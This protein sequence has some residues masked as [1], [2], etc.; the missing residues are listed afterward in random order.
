M[1]G[2]SGWTSELGIQEYVVDN[3]LDRLDR[4]GLDEESSRSVVEFVRRLLMR[5]ERSA[6]GLRR[7]LRDMSARARSLVLVPATPR[8]W[9]RGRPPRTRAWSAS[10]LLPSRANSWMPPGVR[11]E[12][13]GPMAESGAAGLESA[14]ATA[15]TR[16]AI[17]NS[18]PP[19]LVGCSHHRT[20]SGSRCQTS[21]TGTRTGRRS[22]P[23]KRGWACSGMASC[24]ASACGRCRRSRSSQIAGIGPTIASL[25]GALQNRLLKRVRAGVAELG[26]APYEHQNVTIGEDYRLEWP[27]EGCDPEPLARSIARAS[28]LC[29]RL[30]YLFAFCPRCRTH[31]TRYATHSTSRFPWSGAELKTEAWLP[32]SKTA[33]TSTTRSLRQERGGSLPS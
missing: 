28:R 9:S 14:G 8:R 12:P 25:R 7:S 33:K 15:S 29:E 31:C 1:R 11:S 30:A 22:S 27:F 2:C 16:I 17:S 3:F 10:L 24:S 5:E 26:Y 23:R 21:P 6:F 19:H 18:S 20:K 13:T 32:A 4:F